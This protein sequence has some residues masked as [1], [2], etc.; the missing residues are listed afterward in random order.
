[1]C[2]CIHTYIHTH[3]QRVG[4]YSWYYI[5]SP[6]LLVLVTGSYFLLLPRAMAKVLSIQ[7]SI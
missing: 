1:M 4:I 5:V 2:V 3:T 7:Q 6:H